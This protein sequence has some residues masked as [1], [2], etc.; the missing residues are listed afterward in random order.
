MSDDWVNELLK[1]ALSKPSEAQKALDKK[2]RNLA[3]LR[4]KRW[5][6]EHPKEVLAIEARR[7][8]RKRAAIQEPIRANFLALAID[9]FGGRCAY[10]QVPFSDHVPAELDHFR[11]YARGGANAEYNLVPTCQPCNSAKNDKDP[12]VFIYDLRRFGL[13]RR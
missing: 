1:I 3:V 13:F 2:R 6:Q 7:Q 9:A 8:A 12:F 10:C 5:K 4:S 11:S